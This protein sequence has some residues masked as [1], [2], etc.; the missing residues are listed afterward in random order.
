[1]FCRTNFLRSVEVC[2]RR[3]FSRDSP[4]SLVGRVA[5]VT[6][7]TDGIGLAIAKRLAI[8]G[9]RVVVSSRKQKNVDR[10]EKEMKDLG[11]EVMGIQGHVA[12]KSDRKNLIEKTLEEWGEINILVQ[13]AGVNP[14]PFDILSTPESVL[15]KVYDVHIKSNFQMIQEIYPHMAKSK[16]PGS[17]ILSST[18]GAY[19][20]HA[21]AGAYAITKASINAMVRAFMPDLL[22]CNIRINCLT[23]GLVDTAFLQAPASNKEARDKF[24]SAVAMGRFAQPEEC[25]GLAA[26]LASDD[27]SYVTGENFVI[28][29]GLYTRP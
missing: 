14:H 8:N 16:A 5:V 29:G 26:Y 15:D 2:A 23:L 4:G 10:A 25:A 18:V 17:I 21:Y 22:K 19:V 13:N 27:S 3:N 7:G 24:M 12:N 28:S 11:L 6:A 20:T 1:M 9:A